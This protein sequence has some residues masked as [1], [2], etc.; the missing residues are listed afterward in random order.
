MN[1]FIT[2]INGFVGRHL[3]QRLAA[4]YHV[5]G[6]DAANFDIRDATKLRAAIHRAKPDWVFHL[7][8]QSFVPSSHGSPRETWEINVGG[9]LNVLE[10]VRERGKGR[11]LLVSSIEVYGEPRG[12][13][14]EMTP[15]ASG[16][17]Y[18]ASKLA[19]EVLG[20]S[21]AVSHGV[22]LVIVRA[23][24]HVGPGQSSR[25]ALSDWA[26]QLA[27]GARVLRVGNLRPRRD[28]SDV[29]DVARAYEMAMRRGML[30]E[31]Y[32]VGSGVTVTMKEVLEELIVESGVAAR[33]EVDSAKFR[34]NRGHD[35]RFD[36]GKFRRATGWRPQIGR[37]KTLCDILEYWKTCGS[38]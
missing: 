18:A 14:T 5:T 37:Q 15:V 4:R 2:G 26:R 3:R 7:A 33:V 31:V 8:G 13:V 35:F 32:N 24:N 29:R 11:V 27:G 22:D 23:S 20:R 28:I 34:P 9:S 12:R 17:P 38:S 6:V 1:V 21:Y 19:M 10:A 16:N 30:G 25:F 36:C